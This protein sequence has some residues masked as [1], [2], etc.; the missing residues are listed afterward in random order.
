MVSDALFWCV[1]RQQQYTHIKQINTSFFFLNLFLMLNQ[2]C[3]LTT[4]T[5]GS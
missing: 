3:R 1:W 4:P 2:P 5:L